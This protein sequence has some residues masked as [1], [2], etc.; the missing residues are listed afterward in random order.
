MRAWRTCKARHD[1]LDGTGAALEGGRW[2]SA[3]RPLVYAAD[4]FA[5]SI[6][7]IL[8]HSGRPRTLPGPH[9]AVAIDIPAE[10]VERLEPDDLPGWDLPGALEARA[11]GD[12]WLAGSRSAVLVVPSVPSRPVGRTVLINPLHEDA[13]RIIRSAAFAVPWDERLF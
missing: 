2:N 11:Y 13:R 5:G 10:L 1:P 12:A 4:T 9:H 8:V 3:G 6:L 7:E